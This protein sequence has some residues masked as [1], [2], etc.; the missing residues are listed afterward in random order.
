MCNIG[1]AAVAASP[2]AIPFDA[3][4]RAPD[5]P[6]S[7]IPHAIAIAKI[8]ALILNFPFRDVATGQAAR[9]GRL[10]RIETRSILTRTENC[11]YR[12]LPGIC[13]GVFPGA[14]LPLI[15]RTMSTRPN[16]RADKLSKFRALRHD[17]GWGLP[18]RSSHRIN[19][20]LDQNASPLKRN[21]AGH[22]QR[23]RA[24]KKGAPSVSGEG[25]VASPRAQRSTA[26]RP[27]V[28]RQLSHIH[29]QKT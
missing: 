16:G 11:R 9:N 28:G 25:V 20:S 10:P 4:A 18:R 15:T 22:A 6:I 3:P 8:A 29:R 19:L 5:A 17:T 7:P 26:R 1:D 27:A 14:G 23:L 12:G 2:I 24:G 13:T 21:A